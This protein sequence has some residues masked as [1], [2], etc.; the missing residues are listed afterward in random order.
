[1]SVKILEDVQFLSI[2]KDTFQV[3]RWESST[4][5]RYCLL[6]PT[7]MEDEVGGKVGVV[8]LDPAGFEL[9]LPNCHGCRFVSIADA[10]TAA[11]RAVDRHI[12]ESLQDGIQDFE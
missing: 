1:M 3:R 2:Y 4:L 10:L 9:F 11:I 8:I 6:V 12:T 7:E 5:Y